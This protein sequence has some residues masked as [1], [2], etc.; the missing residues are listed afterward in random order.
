MPFQASSL[1]MV[2]STRMRSISPVCAHGRGSVT[3]WCASIFW[4]SVIGWDFCL[5]GIAMYSF[6]LVEIVG[7]CLPDALSV[8]RAQGLCLQYTAPGKWEAE[9][10][11]GAIRP[12]DRDTGSDRRLARR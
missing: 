3:A 7:L 9:A 12:C 5:P 8:C 10:A 1:A 4:V 6:V 2:Q 11:D